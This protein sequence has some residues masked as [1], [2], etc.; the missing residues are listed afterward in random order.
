VYAAVALRCDSTLVTLD[1]EQLERL[2]A[3]ITTRRPAEAVE[4]WE[5]S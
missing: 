4:E 5:R 3:V 1:G 2:T